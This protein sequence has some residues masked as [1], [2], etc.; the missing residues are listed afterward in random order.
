MDFIA[1]KR[2]RQTTQ[3]SNDLY[4]F[5][6]MNN[7]YGEFRQGGKS[8]MMSNKKVC[9]EREKSSVRAHAIVH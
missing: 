3:V 5:F 8:H 4:I 9:I 7:K 2:I 6:F 1:K